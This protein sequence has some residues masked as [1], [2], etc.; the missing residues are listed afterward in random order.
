[1]C[2]RSQALMCEAV[3]RSINVVV[4]VKLLLSSLDIH[5]SLHV[6]KTLFTKTHWKAHLSVIKQPN[7]CSWLQPSIWLLFFVTIKSTAN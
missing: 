5:S 7:T 2:E 4:T 1:L 6:V 3:G